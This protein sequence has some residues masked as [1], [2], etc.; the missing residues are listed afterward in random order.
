MLGAMAAMEA[1]R[2]RGE[3]E[4]R[5]EQWVEFFEEGEPNGEGDRSEPF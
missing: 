5:R 3:F 1:D 2:R 4:E